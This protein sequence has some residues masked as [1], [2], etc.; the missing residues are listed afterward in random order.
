VSIADDRKVSAWSTHAPAL[1]AWTM[2]HL[3]NRRDAYGHYIAVEHR[4]DP[5]Q[6]A[7]TDKSGLTLEK[8]QL[9]YVGRSTGDLLG[10]HST[11]RDA[12]GKCWSTWLAVDID[13]H[14]D[15]VDPETTLRAAL[16]WYAIA[17]GLGF[18]VLLFDSNGAGGYHLV[19][20]FDGPVPTERVFAFGK[21]LTRDS[22][23]LGL[24]E[25][26]EIF[27][28]QP[29]L[30]GKGYGNWLRLPGRHHT[31]D[32]VS[33][34][35]DGKTW[36]E[37][38]AAIKG[39]L[40]TTGTSAEVIPAETITTPKPERKARSKAPHEVTSDAQLARDALQYL[41]PDCSYDQWLEIGMSLTPLGDEG[42][43]LWDEWSEAGEGKYR[44]G[45]CDRKW[46]SFNRSGGRT[47]GSLFHV[48]KQRGWAAPPKSNGKAFSNGTSNG[49]HEPR[50][51]SDAKGEAPEDDGRPDDHLGKQGG[52]R[53]DLPRFS[54]WAWEEKTTDEGEVKVVKKGKSIVEIE[55][56]L[57]ALFG[58]WPKRVVETLFCSTPDHEP[59]YLGSS[60]RLLAWIG[61]RAQ[62]DWTK[63][64]QF[65]TQEQFFEHLRMTSERY[66]AIESIPHWPPIEGIY[67][68]H[69]PVPE[70]SGKLE[71]FLDFFTPHGAEDRELIKALV[72]TPF[73]GGGPGRRPAV[74]VTGPDHDPEQGRGVGKTTMLDVIFDELL[75]GS[76]DVSP[77]A[78]MD[79]VKTRL[80][81]DQA[82]RIRAA[83]I[84]NI[85]TLKLSW[86]DLEGLITAAS[87]SGHAMYKGEGRRPNTLVW[88]LTLNG[89]SLSKDM[90][91]RCAIIKLGRPKF[92]A[93]WE[94][95]L[96]DYVREHRWDLIADVGQ[97]L[98]SMA[99]P[100]VPKTRWAAWEQGVLSKVR[101]AEACQDL[102]YERMMTA[103]TD[104]EEKEVVAEHF[105][106]KLILFHH[107]PDDCCV[108]IPSKVAG[109]WLADACQEKRPTNRA[110]AYLSGL[111][112]PELRKSK[113]GQPGWAWTGPKARSGAPAVW[114]DRRPTNGAPF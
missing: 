84:D 40:K 62:V 97:I 83:R 56:S 39:I 57:R 96:R 64:S 81:S 100:L 59:I 107:D 88:G 43:R 69:R 4:E 67:Y 109:E 68:M 63:G 15:S 58:P 20:V 98:T 8:L 113:K 110:T 114:F 94:E 105:R 31:K 71:G 72:I 35:W 108:F 7:F 112:I 91:Q 3:V 28:K 21:W 38:T 52:K 95:R 9:H 61:R 26:P 33:R 46:R 78:D 54:N 65:V 75:G 85:K 79:T 99:G 34:L 45:L 2:N 76:I 25:A 49:Y 16:A 22:K 87:I 50:A 42:L 102:V 73:W 18:R 17:V 111:G 48:A 32:H 24:P 77:T 103:D 5:D 70:P 29:T 12:E 44:E 104:N 13:R 30:T 14:D 10:L 89:A 47:L 90:A 101:L 41:D 23:A 11:V 92:T 55:E 19:L 74:L 36:L 66:E 80:L 60:A 6:T 106:E 37:G 27:P 86:A 93:D 1:A 53:K 82:C 51:V